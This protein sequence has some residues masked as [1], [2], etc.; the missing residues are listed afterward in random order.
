MVVWG[1]EKYPIMLKLK[2]VNADKNNMIDK[3]YR[4]IGPETKQEQA[5]AFESQPHVDVISRISYALFN[6]IT[7][8]GYRKVV[9]TQIFTY[10][11]LSLKLRL[12]YTLVGSQ[13]VGEYWEVTNLSN[14]PIKLHEQNFQEEGVFSVSMLQNNLS[15]GGTTPMYITRRAYKEQ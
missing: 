10:P 4:F 13:Y 5:T 7:P 8:K 3:Y 12:V 11:E 14:N 1:Y 2:F 6:K 15:A 9:N